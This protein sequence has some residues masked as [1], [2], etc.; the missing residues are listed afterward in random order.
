MGSDIRLPD[1]FSS[2]IR[3]QILANPLGIEGPAGTTKI[4]SGYILRNISGQVKNL[5]T[6]LKY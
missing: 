6:V 4:F 2:Q 3:H 5:L 1:F